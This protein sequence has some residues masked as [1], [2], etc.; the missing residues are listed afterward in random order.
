MIT[1][2]TASGGYNAGA[3][4]VS[5]TVPSG[6]IRVDDI[7]YFN[8]A[9][10]NTLR[11][12]LWKATAADGGGNAAFSTSIASTSGSGGFTSVSPF[13]PIILSPGSYTLA[14]AGFLA[15]SFYGDTALADSGPIYTTDARARL[16][17]S[18]LYA[19][20][21]VDPTQFNPANGQ[22]STA[23]KRWKSVNFSYTSVPEPETFAVVA[24]THLVILVMV[25]AWRRRQN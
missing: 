12:G 23:T 18:D 25:G 6:G 5:F 8:V 14:V 16:F 10:G 11:I 20:S 9:A 7:R 13:T 2:N 19:A 3:L 24:G 21:I 22:L 17:P 15:A 4:G 1:D